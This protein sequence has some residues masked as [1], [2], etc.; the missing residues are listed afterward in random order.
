MSLSYVTLG[1]NDPAKA[2]PFYAALMAPLGGTMA[3]DYEGFTFC[4]ELPDGG[5]MWIT[6]PQNKLEASVGNGVTIGIT[7]DSEAKVDAAHAAGLMA[8]GINEGDPGPRPDFGPEFYGA[9]VRDLD[10]NKLA[11]VHYRAL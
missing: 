4:Y 9:Y 3:A 6:R 8:G 11:L 10:G 2:K 5:K 7:T 1:T